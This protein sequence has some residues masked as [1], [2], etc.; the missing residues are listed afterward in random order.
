MGG[1]GRKLPYSIKV[2]HVLCDNFSTVQALIATEIK[3]KR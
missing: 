1:G 2:V 3:A